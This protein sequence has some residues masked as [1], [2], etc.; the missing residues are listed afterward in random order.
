M[1]LTGAAEAQVARHLGAGRGL[2]PASFT[3]FVMERKSLGI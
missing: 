2:K 1:L 3:A